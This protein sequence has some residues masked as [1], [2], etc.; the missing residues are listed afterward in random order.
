MRRIVVLL[1]SLG[2]LALAGLFAAPSVVAGDP[3]YHGFDVPERTTA[4]ETQIKM[5]PCAFAPT[6]TT[7][8]AGSTVTFFNGPDFTHLITGANA[9]W[10]SRDVEVKPGAEVS[11]TFNKAG[12]YPYS[13]ALHRGMSGTI[14]VG[15]LAAAVGA[16]SATG[17]T[18]AGTTTGGTT[19]GGTTGQAA[20]ASSESTTPS[21]VEPVAIVAGAGAGAI[22]GAAAVWL[23]MRRRRTD[24]TEALG[25]AD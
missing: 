14:V 7:V 6:V 18:G 8:A 15:D 5:A 24:L 17:A 4:S 1:M 23:A 25:R 22:A 9:E 11:Y 16:G 12:I 10:G 2:L 20:A 13:C 21:G 19:T 3:C